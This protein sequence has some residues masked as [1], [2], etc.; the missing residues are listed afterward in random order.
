MATHAAPLPVRSQASIWSRFYGFGSVYAKTLR[1]SRLAVIIVGGLIIGLMAYGW[2]AIPLVITDRSQGAKLIEDLPPIL[3]GMGGNPVNI[4]SIGGYISW[5]YGPFFAIVAGLW[6]ILALSGTLAAEARK[7]SLDIVAASPFGKRRLALEKL[8]AHVTGVAAIMIVLAIVTAL[9]TAAFSVKPQDHIAVS[10]SIGFSLWLGLVALACGSVAWA[11]APFLGRA[12]AA[13]VAGAYML[14]GYVISGYQTVLPGLKPLASLTPFYWTY[15]EVPLA[16]QSDWP[17]LIPVAA[18]AVVLF[19]VGVE[20]FQRR[21]LG[22]SSAIPIPAMPGALL[23]T[24]GPIRRAFGERLPLALAWGVGLAIFAGLIAGSSAS[25]ASELDSIGEFKRALGTIFPKFDISTSSGFLQLMFAYI[26]YIV[27]GLG[28]ATLVS[29]WAN[30]EQDRQLEML[31]A[32]PMTRTRWAV[33]GGIGIFAALLVMT[34]LTMA[35]IAAG[36]LLAGGDV[37]TPTIGALNVALWAAAVAGIG[38]A[39]GGIWRTSLAAEVAALFAIA[40]FLIDFLGPALKLPDWFNQLALTSHL[41]LPMVGI[42]DW[43]GVAA[44]LALAAGGLLLGGL[45]MR[46]R[47]VV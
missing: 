17:T 19:I 38:L 11:L 39:V 4:D 40:T 12:S 33:T 9:C 18:L 27:A 15:N 22:V 23:G 25:F 16:G 47:D 37:V 29:G 28:A 3:K 36:V 5:K 43:F 10:E 44:C 31:L 30:E 35:G 6:S 34:S 13:G 41:G 2:V 46:R 26:A 8:G 24:T 32:T 21:D 1:D 14:A 42:W 45:G 7:G 20:A